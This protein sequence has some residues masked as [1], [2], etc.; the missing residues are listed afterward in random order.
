MTELEILL[1][2]E[3][4]RKSFYEFVKAFWSTADPSKFIDG[5][6]IQF[7]CESF[8][9]M[10]RSWVGYTPISIKLPKKSDDIDIIDVRENKNRLNINVPPRHTKSMI[11][12]VFGPT[13]LWIYHPII[14]AS[15]SH[16]GKLSKK[17]NGKRYNIINSQL[18]KQLYSNIKLV[19]NTQESLLDNRGGEL[20][21]QSRESM[22]G[23][24][25]DLLI[26]DDLMNAETA[27]RDKE[28]A[29]SARSYYKN[30]MPSRINN[31]DKCIIINIQQRLAPNDITGM[32]END[33]G[34]RDLYTFIVLPAQFKK[35]TYL[36]CPI[37]GDVF[38][39]NKD[40]YLWPERFG[41]Y[42]ALKADVGGETG[43]TWETQYMQNPIA[44]DKTIIKQDMIIEK[45]LNE[46]PNIDK[47]EIIYG[48]H[49]FPVKD[50][51]TSD[52]LGSVLAYRVGTNLYLIDC[53]EKRMAFKKSV[54]YV[55]N[56][57]AY[58]P[59]IIQIIEDK[60]NGSPI[61]EQLQDEVA[62]LQPFQPGTDSK[63]TR[64]DSASYY[65]NNIIFV[66]TVFDKFT[67][68]Y[69]LSKAL[70][71]LKDRLL[72][73]PFVEH[74]D[75]TDAFSML[76]LFVFLDRRYMV[77][78]RAFNDKNIID[79]NTIKEL[80]YST[81]F[82][83]KEGDIW[84]ACEIAIKYGEQTQ[85]I[86]KRETRFKASIEDG[87]KELKIFSP[88]SSIF[89]DCSATDA[90]KGMIKKDTTIERYE[91][92][93]FDQSVSQTNLA[94]SKKSILINKDC[95]LTKTD[96]EN[97][98]YSKTKDDENVKYIST[99]DGFVACIRVALHYYGGII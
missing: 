8:Q 57:E 9:Y 65:M 90:M 35:K 23:F 67:H 92:E 37:S 96:I 11:F 38:I 18:F 62:G 63:A 52:F 82:F 56:L 44:T 5:K 16:S 94:F 60:A 27:K 30:T 33:I 1:R 29:A 43:S 34:L 41:N 6:L 51:E 53:L 72:N 54:E 98:K 93:D 80:N 68:T 85:I 75:I 97:F 12:N 74:D 55:R 83:N 50:K 48:S 20:Y 78:G 69:K 21:S 14:A 40:D 39:F 47:A 15:I 81:I 64:L 77:Y 2:K 99:K 87:L 61:L 22:T 24:G 89:I 73:F 17:M 42:E 70:E 95:V 25:A 45:D 36:V 32:I 76:I 79:I 13:W 86:V 59:G 71:N 31:P 66:R 19:T 49:D 88:K 26:N 84:K 91:I 7:Y 4:Y 58:Y 28:E 10:C 3:L 46:V